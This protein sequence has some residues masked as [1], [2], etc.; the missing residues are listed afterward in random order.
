M[1][2]FSEHALRATN[3]VGLVEAMNYLLEHDNGTKTE[4]AV[5]ASQPQAEMTEQQQGGQKAA[6][7][8]QMESSSVVQLIDDDEPTPASKEAVAP[9]PPS[10]TTAQP[11]S[12]KCL[13][14]VWLFYCAL[15][16]EC[17]S[18]CT[19]NTCS[20]MHFSTI[21]RCEKMFADTDSLSM[22]AEISKHGRF[23]ESTEEVKPL[24]DEEKRQ[25]LEAAQAKLKEIRVKKQEQERKE[26]IEKEIKRRR[27]GQSMIEAEEERKQREMK[28]WAEAKKREKREVIE[29]GA[30]FLTR[31]AYFPVEETWILSQEE[32]ARR[33]VLEQIKMDREARK[34]ADNSVAAASQSIQ[35]IVMTTPAAISSTDTRLQIRLPDGSLIRETFEAN[36]I[37]ASVRVWAQMKGEEKGAFRGNIELISPFPRKTFSQ[38][39]YAKPLKALGQFFVYL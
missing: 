22:H 4:P 16:V 13:V 24:T 9:Q 32:L 20:H 31:A 18:F 33:R 23:E 39:D 17:F 12:F 29:T 3:E 38:D 36:E 28:E 37:L 30:R 8:D 19:S 25:R 35:P 2:V 21:F 1:N 26:A 14:L 10:K 5:S 34:T 11:H 27:D 6:A 15:L 7:V